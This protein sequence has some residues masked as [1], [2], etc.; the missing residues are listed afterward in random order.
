LN[1]SYDEAIATM[2]EIW[3][4]RSFRNTFRGSASM[5]FLRALQVAILQLPSPGPNRTSVSIFDP[6]PLMQRIDEVVAGFGGVHPENRKSELRALAVMTTLEETRRRPLL[7]VSMKERLGA[8]KLRGA[9][10][11]VCYVDNLVAAHAFASAALPSVLP[12]IKLNLE[13][14]Q[15]R[16]V[17][18]GISD[19]LPVDPSV[20]L[21]AAKVVAIDISGRRWWFLQS[22]RPI[23]SQDR[24]EVRADDGTYCLR[25]TDGLELRNEEPFGPLLKA[26]VGG[27]GRS[28][29]AALGPTWPI[30]KLLARKL[31]EDWAYEVMTYVVINEDFVAAL[32]QRG[33]DDA[34][35]ALKKYVD[36]LEAEAA[37]E[38][39]S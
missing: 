17:D 2:E 35:R 27:S 25:P 5:S 10:F 13:T 19:N 38:A 28:L 7:V 4:E 39:E 34:S 37:A 15:V 31:G 23:Y 12:P 21:G 14:R 3:R 22:G 9:S 16:L 18:G 1:S 32:L 8:Y 24:W 33:H 26:A 36:T 29:I 6:T 11:E 30:F 20:R